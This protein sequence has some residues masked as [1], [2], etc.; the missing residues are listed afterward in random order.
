MNIKKDFPIFENNP[1]IIFL[2]STS[3]SQ[4]PKHVIDGM[5]EYLEKSYSNIHR[6]MYDLAQESEKLYLD[7]KKKVAD[8]IW[9][10]SWREII[11]T[12][13]ST[14]AANI[15]ASSVGASDMLKKWDI[16]LLSI[17]E[18]HANIVPWQILAKQTGAQIQYV[19]IKNDY[20]LD[21]DDFYFK[22][23]NQKIKIVSMTHVSNVT[24]EIFPLKLIGEEVKK[25]KNTPLFF[26]DASQSVPHFKVDVEKLQCDA[27]FFT[28]HKLFADSGIGVLY[29]RRKFLEELT[30]SIGGW[31]AISWVHEDDFKLAPL[32]D[33]FEPGTPNMTWA[34]SLLHA[35]EYIDAIGWYKTIESIEHDLIEYMLEQIWSREYIEKFIGPKTMYSRVW[36]FSFTMKNIHVSDLADQLAENNIC[37][38]SGQ[39]CTEPFMIKQWI[40]GS[41]RVS[42]HIYNTR[43][44]IDRL[45]E[46]LDMIQKNN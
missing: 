18:H 27:L 31:G 29:G 13:N 44:D 26:I 38:R 6:G 45:F 3:S 46:V 10:T 43:E 11:Y 2:D 17:V 40:S 42:F 20:S 39:H 24:W 36:V 19:D 8:Y 37:V 33:R 4:K 30:P 34:V 25:H 15:L 5:K 12:M 7:S 16:I 28:G 41:C 35:L 23:R 9:A 21:M 22:M 1:W 14:Y 32:P